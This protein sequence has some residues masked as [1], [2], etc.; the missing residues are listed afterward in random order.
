MFKSISWQEYLYGIG[1]LA[2]GYYIVIVAIYY[3][4]D[5]LA[6]V[7]GASVSKAKSTAVNQP[8][9]KEKFMGAISDAPRKKI[10]IKQSLAVSEELS[11]EV[12]PEKLL[13]AQ[14][15]DSPAS[16]LYERLEDFFKAMKH[17]KVKR[18]KLNGIKTFF[19]QYPSF[20]NTPIRQEV[21]G[22]VYDH[23]R[24]NTEADF[25][26]KEIDILWFDDK[27]E[28]IHQSTTINNYEK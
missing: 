27:Q 21:T 23:F 2:V 8:L 19:T 17:E 20:K 13:A 7:K 18:P 5:I 4:R 15:A 3:S 1:L 28:I 26:R 22:Y 25:T 10:P 12:D 9:T 11:M 6:K 14:R 16:E 24:K